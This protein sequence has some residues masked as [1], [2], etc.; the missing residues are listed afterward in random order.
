MSRTA[1]DEAE[2]AEEA[3]PRYHVDT[4]WFAENGLSFDDIARMRLCETCLAKAGTVTEERVAVLDEKSG[5]SKFEMH[6]T[7]YGSD[8]VRVIREHCG[9]VKNYVHRDMPSLEAIFRVYLANGNDPLSLD[10]V[11]E[12]L[13]EWC[14]G[15]GCQWL[16]LPM[17]TL[18]RLVRN[19][20]FYGL[21]EFVPEGD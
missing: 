5:K 20:A 12:H 1:L 8:P 17:D 21:R 7:T 3:L 10:Q 15:G 9:R 19:D 2:G 4:T 16:L 14:P 11:R 18:D 6:S 13:A